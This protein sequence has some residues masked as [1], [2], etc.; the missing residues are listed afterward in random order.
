MKA[1]NECD[2][3]T[4][5]EPPSEPTLYDQFVGK[6]TI[7]RGNFP[8]SGIPYLVILTHREDG[9]WV[10]D[11]TTGLIFVPFWRPKQVEYRQNTI[12]KIET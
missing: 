1:A 7:G 3:D 5:G 9:T 4:G 11:T 6:T 8:D 2:D 10:D 12:T